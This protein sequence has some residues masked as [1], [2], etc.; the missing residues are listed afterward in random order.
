MAACPLN[1]DNFRQFS[2]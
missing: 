2:H 1:A